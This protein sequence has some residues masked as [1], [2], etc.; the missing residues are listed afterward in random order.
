MHPW[1]A[2]DCAPVIAKLADLQ[3]VTI[4]AEAACP[5]YCGRVIRN[6]DPKAQTPAGWCGVWSAAGCA[7]FIRW[8]ISPIMSA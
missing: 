3:P 5:S 8:S 2:V 7:R 1:L 6:I 4:S